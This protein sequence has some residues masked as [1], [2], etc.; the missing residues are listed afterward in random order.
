MF[1]SIINDI[2]WLPFTILLLAAFVTSMVHG[3]T[4]IAG[5][6]LLTIVATPILGLKLVVPVISI[7]LLISHGSRAL[8]NVRQFDLKTY[9][10][11]AIPAI[12]CI[13]ITALLYGR[14]S[15][16]A[17]A[18]ILGTVVLASVPLRRWA[19]ARKIKTSKTGL[20]VAGGVYGAISGMSIG[21]GMLLMPVLLGTGMS[22][23]AF[24]ATLA[25]I[26]LTTNLVR[27]GVYGASDL[28]NGPHVVLA[29]L[30]GLATIP[31]A[32]VGR[33][34]LRRMTD[35]RHTRIVEL[36]VITGGLYFY[37]IAFN[38]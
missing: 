9:F 22:K 11:V 1:E 27:I 37:W 36:L 15:G 24:V 30:V 12:P 21:P 10:A 5:G 8:F 13:I 17:I 14:L 20:H 19:T 35:E 38:S 3:A 16:P 2:G 31:G 6:F 7:T 18:I 23:Q 26:A 32:W 4:G 28:L 29:I 33:A 34:V 25:V